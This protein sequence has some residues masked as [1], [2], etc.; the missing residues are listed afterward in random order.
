M[1][2]EVQLAFVLPLLLTLPGMAVVS[3]GS[4]WQQWAPLQR[5]CLAV[6]LSIAVYP[7]GFYLVRSLSAEITLGPLK[8]AALLIV[9]GAI[10]VWRVRRA[11]RDWFG[12]DRLEWLALV[13]IAATLFTRFWIIRDQPFPAWS[14]S[15]HHTLLTQLTAAQGR[16]PFNMEPYFPIDLGQYHLGLYA[17]TGSA[18]MLS[19]APA[20]TALLWTAQAL[21]GLCGLGVYLVLDRKVGR[22]GAVVGAVVA[23]LW[24]FQ[25]AWYVNWGRF[26]QVSSQTIML[27]A[28]IVS[29]ETLRAFRVSDAQTS[30]LLKP[31]VLVAAV[32]NAAT[33]LMHFRVA[34]FYIPLLLISQL[35]ELGQAS[36]F[37]QRRKLFAGIA[38]V[39][40]ASLVVILPAL[41]DALWIHIALSSAT[42]I[43]S[44]REVAQN[45]QDYFAFPLETVT[46]LAAKPWLLAVTGFALLLGW[47][48]RSWF[49]MGM[50]VWCT[51]A[52]GLGYTYL[53]GIAAL[54]LTNLGA[55]LIMLYLPI[56]LIV[57]AATAVILEELNLTTSTPALLT[58]TA[59]LV[60]SGLVTGQ[61]RATEIE[62][63]RYFVS[64]SDLDA[65]EWI[66]A[67]TPPESVFAIN[68]H[69]WLP[70]FP[71]GT[72]AGYWIPYLADR[73][74]T[75]GCMLLPLAPP[76]YFTW[77]I[78]S[79]KLVHRLAGDSTAVAQLR[80]LGVGYLYLGERG[81]NLDV[82]LDT[83]KLALY[84]GLEMV[85]QRDEVKIYK[86]LP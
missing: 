57:G 69:F 19:G 32:L 44:A 68:T 9:C 54:N 23:G 37:K 41:I 62:T 56:S 47:V 21:N 48:R 84:P 35:W 22:W 7:V 63:H 66:K 65:M 36:R 85:Y 29:W 40:A 34:A 72:D 86:V 26:T 70:V 76:V 25:P 12:F 38:L 73:R 64:P 83:T 55:V 10:V 79:S 30:S 17:L 27:V 39:G 28:W 53:L 78:E 4:V 16:L 18:Q 14:D 33:F 59:V 5:W 6:A 42:S 15:L 43:A 75:A 1:P 77:V 49:I 50:T 2:A 60:A 67:N 20:H 13:V 74:T 46:G 81:D 82:T 61:A 45:E 31:S 3:T 24:S 71:H 52:I 80:E 11:W 8:L 58:L 51:T